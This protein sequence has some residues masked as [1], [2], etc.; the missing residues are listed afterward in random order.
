MRCRA[1]GERG[2]KSGCLV[3][4]SWR[5]A[6]SLPSI[7]FLQRGRLCLCKI[8]RGNGSHSFALVCSFLSARSICSRVKGMVPSGRCLTDFSA[9]LTS[10]VLLRPPQQI[11]RRD[12]V[13][14][15]GQF[16]PCLIAPLTIML[17]LHLI[18]YSQLC[19]CSLLQAI[20]A[21]VDPLC[22][23]GSDHLWSHG[24]ARLAHP[25]PPQRSV[26]T[27]PS[28]SPILPDLWSALCL[29]LFFSSCMSC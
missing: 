7:P 27:F 9:R 17:T 23:P 14:S 20:C 26:C 10:P 12:P 18:V 4:L 25:R 6:S 24:Q 3:W 21:Q 1:G 28:S 13:S 19:Q 2:G 15:I 29:R 16:S 5:S 22:D 8:G 11:A